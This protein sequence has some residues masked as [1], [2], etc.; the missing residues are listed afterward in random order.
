MMA[1]SAAASGQDTLEEAAWKMGD[2]TV[3]V[4]F[5]EYDEA[6]MRPFLDKMGMRVKCFTDNPITSEQE[7]YYSE[8]DAEG[9]AEIVMPI[10]LENQE[11]TILMGRLA[12]TLILV[13]NGGVME[14]N[15]EFKRLIDDGMAGRLQNPLT[16]MTWTGDNSEVNNCAMKS[17]ILK[18][19]YDSVLNYD[20]ETYADFKRNVLEKLAYGEERADQLEASQRTKEVLKIWMKGTAGYY[21]TIADD[22]L[23]SA[24][25]RIHNMPFETLKPEGFVFPEYDA[26]YFRFI[27]EMEMNSR[28]MLY[29]NRL[30]D[31]AIAF[32]RNGQIQSRAI[33]EAMR[34]AG[35][36]DQTGVK[37]A[38]I[39]TDHYYNKRDFTKEEMDALDEFNN[40]HES[41]QLY[42]EFFREMRDDYN[43]D[44]IGGTDGIIIDLIECHLAMARLN[45]KIGVPEENIR[46]LEENMEETF[47]AEYAKMRNQKLTAD[48]EAEKVKGGYN[49]HQSD[50]TEADALLVD[51]VSKYPGRVV[52]I[53]MWATWCGP[54]KIGIQAMKEHE[55]ELEKMGV[56]TV[57]IT[58]ESSPE[59]TWNAMI[60]SMKGDHYRLSTAVVNKLKAK[61]GF[62]GIPSYIFINKKGEVTY[63]K[64]G[65]QGA[66]QFVD[67]LKEMAAE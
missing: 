9:K 60:P 51:I 64:T 30:K 56:A 16:Y 43:T 28:E 34:T 6:T 52:F 3:K 58:D 5:L 10:C 32:L 36:L 8:I 25:C 4:S 50:E 29:S 23:R 55:E 62:N 18:E 42:G 1:V 57:Y 37:V 11:A 44:V 2:A 33:L 22:L 14:C 26:D 31:V 46:Y 63:S 17:G 40:N 67:R 13:R 12:N 27:R 48:M 35:K 65:F 41:A 21:L 59:E 38:D 66:E 54:C 20:A 7:I 15:I 47:Y 39:M 61:F 53:D 24:Y 45:D 49:V 19:M